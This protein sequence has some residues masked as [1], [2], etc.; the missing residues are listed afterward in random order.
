MIIRS[1]LTGLVA[2]AVLAPS[3]FA[4]PISIEAFAT[5][6]EF[7]DL[8]VAPGGK[9]VAVR[10]N[11]DNA[12]RVA[13][14]D[15]SGEQ[16]QL[17]YSLREDETFSASWFRWASP[18]RLIVSI[19]FVGA[20]GGLGRVDT[21]ER[22]LFSVKM[23]E[24]EMVPVFYTRR[25][26]VP[27]QI[28]DDV[29]SFLP[30]DPERILVQYNRSN[31]AEP[32]VYSA[33][34][35]TSTR[36]SRVLAKRRNIRDWTADNA[37]NIR[38]ARGLT[39]KRTRVLEFRLDGEKRWKDFS[40]RVADPSAV[41]WPAGF[42]ADP[43]TVY[44]VSNHELDPAGLYTFDL[45]TDTF[46][47]LIFNHPSVDISSV[48][49]NA[50]N[51]EISNVNFVDAQAETVWF[52]KSEINQ[53]L[54]ELGEKFPNRS[55]TTYG[56]SSDRNH[57]I[58]RLSGNK[59]PG[60]FLIYN[61]VDRQVKLLPSQYPG[62]QGVSLANTVV[63]EYEA[64]DGLTIPAFITLPTGISSLNE[65]RNL[66]FIINPHGGPAAR[67]FLRFSFDVQF[68][69]SRG[70]GVLQMN[71]RGSS[72][73]GTEFRDAG[74]KEW[75]QAMQDDI[76]DGV[77]WLINQ[78]I[79]DPERI[80]IVGGSYGGYAALMGVVKEPDL[81]QC[82]VSFAGVTD[83]P[84]VIRTSSRYVDGKYRT[85]FIGDL[86]KDRK[87][88]AE[89]SPARR[90]AEIQ[91]PVLLMHGE[92]DTVVD[93]KQSEDMADELARA[94][95]PHEFIVFPDGDHHLSLYE[96]RYRYLAETERFLGQ[97]LADTPSVVER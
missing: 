3:G 2:C 46:G 61:H 77:G 76:T 84:K 71:F 56:I 19:G 18:D 89:N 86:W 60:Q 29:V 64:H 32:L 13:V 7:A 49:I 78:G 52:S 48:R 50:D 93:V 88:L 68:L 31:P 58:A 59:D 51:G 75:G 8:E 42:A 36:H 9:Y 65:A 4:E 73:Y 33:N 67:D 74:K 70:Y 83:L 6:P 85:R 87:M 90:A 97:C 39:P 26:D 38:I 47:E 72:G 12:Y 95:K 62:L 66:P 79:A 16:L 69:A 30:D 27:V 35:T 91:V 25:N 54:G 45:E 57:A 96:N 80:A 34:I 20:R 14:I 82:A 44:V 92:K 63:T 53:A 5:L 15:I 22:R 94:D 1:W 43:N 10:V 40:H 11:I 41:F 81:F 23:G 24:H 55:V 17:V 28:Q 37:G 21:E